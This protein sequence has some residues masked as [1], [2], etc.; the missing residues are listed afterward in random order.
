MALLA[1]G[2]ISNADAVQSQPFDSAH[3]ALLIE[4]L[5][6]VSPK[7]LPGNYRPV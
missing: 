3:S 2:L 1:G 4:L 5:N 6:Q 7:A